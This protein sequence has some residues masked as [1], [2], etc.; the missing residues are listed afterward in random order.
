[1]DI[2]ILLQHLIR[3]ETDQ[4]PADRPPFRVGELIR[5]RVLELVSADRALVDLGK[6][7][8]VAD[9][10]FPVTPGE[11]I[12]V[13]VE[14]I[15]RQLRLRTL[16]PQNVP[17]AG[18]AEAPVAQTLQLSRLAEALQQ[19]IIRVLSGLQ[20]DQT[21]SARPPGAILE[22]LKTVTGLLTPMEPLGDTLEVA[23]RLQQR[24]ESSGLF[25]EKKLEQ[26]LPAPIREG[27]PL[28]PAIHKRAVELAGGDLKA[29]LMV[30]R[31]Y[32]ALSDNLLD[33]HLGDTAARMSRNISGW[34]NEINE[35]Q[36]QSVRQ[37]DPN[38]AYQVLLFELPIRGLRRPGSLKAYFK[39]RR[40]GGGRGG[41]HLSLLL[42]MDRLG[43]VRGDFVMRDKELALSLFVADEP[44]LELLR[45]HAAV[46]RA[47]L[48][49]HFRRVALSI[50]L[51]EQKVRDFERVDLPASDDR[52]INMRV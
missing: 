11:E 17:T 32:L 35:Q 34:L 39:R 28:D 41:F 40:R 30:L 45:T 5:L 6:M 1:M 14:D 19:D 38:Q 4:S 16:P 33:R 42:S 22:A 10:R 49:V 8:A 9:V 47:A 13:R 43:D 37:S 52:R 36:Q 27:E 21:A 18:T 24:V 25:F 29:Q 2:S 26:I 46:V 20:G 31:R 3:T 51:S 23:A 12:E 15:G 48:Q 50:R 7:R 44:T